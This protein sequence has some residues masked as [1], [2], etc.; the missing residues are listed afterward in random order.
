MCN[1]LD[2]LEELTHKLPSF[3][4]FARTGNKAMV[5]YEI[6]AGTLLSKGL[7]KVPE[8]A[9][10]SSFMSKGSK[11]LHHVHK[12]SA[13]YIIIYKGRMRIE[14]DGT[15]SEVGP[16]ELGIIKPNVSHTVVEVLEDCFFIAITVPADKSFPDAT[17]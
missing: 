7:L 9:V 16:G 6:L 10:A 13:E 1:N 5:N 15:T 17:R 8:I 3:S 14:I 2:E 12:D 11:T 4:E